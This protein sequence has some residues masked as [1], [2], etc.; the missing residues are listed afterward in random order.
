MW[1]RFSMTLPDT[2]EEA[3]RS[4]L[5]LLAM[6]ATADV[7]VV[8][9]NVN[10]LISVGLGERGSNDFRLAHLTCAALLK[11]APTKVSSESQALPMRF[12][13][14]HKWHEIFERT[15]KLLVDGLTRLED[16]YYSQFATTAVSLIYTLGEHPD[17][18][19]GE[20]LKKMCAI[21]YS[22]S[23]E[24]SG[25]GE[26]GEI[27]IAP[28]ILTR[29]LVIAG[30]IAIK[31]LIHLDVHVYTELRRRARVREEKQEASSKKRR[32][33]A[34]S[35]S[36]RGGPRAASMANDTADEDEIVGA[37]ADDDE[38][39]YVRKVKNFLLFILFLFNN[40]SSFFF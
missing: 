29:I 15:S 9:S 4:A 8:T 36:R 35:A 5:M 10:V 38:A 39:E 23:Q 28:G 1:E 11:M 13:P 18:I 19:L 24:L 2:N 3:S 31:Q 33:L 14:T 26:S 32:N 37:V 30:Q 7:Q 25:S 20:V 17:A 27:E 21:A 22:R 16:T 12:P 34:M 6:V 40:I